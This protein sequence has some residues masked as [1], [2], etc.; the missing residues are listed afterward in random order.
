[1]KFSKALLGTALAAACALAVASAQARPAQLVTNGPQR[2]LGDTSGWSAHQ[3]VIE[4]ERYDRLVETNPAF[5]AARERK[6]CGPVTDPQLHAQCVASFN[7]YEGANT[8]GGSSVTEP[9]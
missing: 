6:E 5:R 8:Y 9:Y 4:S 2:D 3:N 1:V 7:T